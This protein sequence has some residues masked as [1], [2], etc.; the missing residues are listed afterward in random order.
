MIKLSDTKPAF[1]G[2][3]CRL[4]PDV[5]TWRKGTRSIRAYHYPD[6]MVRMISGVDGSDKIGYHFSREYVTVCLVEHEE[7]TFLGVKPSELR[8]LSLTGRRLRQ[9]EGLLAT[10]EGAAA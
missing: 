9:L 3:V 10:R 2:R 6:A 7:A 4:G 8:K 5:F 1:D